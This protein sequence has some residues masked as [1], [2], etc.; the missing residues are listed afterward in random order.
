VTPSI[1]FVSSNNPP[2]IFPT[3]SSINDFPRPNPALGP[4]QIFESSASS[5]YHALQLEARKR[6]S[7][8]YGFTLAYTFSHAIDNVS[9]L[10]P[11]AGAPILAQNQTRLDLER[12]NA[13]FDIR[14][15]LAASF[16]WDLPFYRSATSGIARWL[17]GWQLAAVFQ[18]NTG[19]PFTLNLPL[20]A[21]L[22]GNLTDR[23]LSEKGL[24]FF[25]GHGA[26]RVAMSPGS[27]IN[28]FFLF[29]TDGYVGRN[30]ARGDSFINLDLALNKRFR[31][32]DR[33]QLEFRM[34]TFNLLNR[35][36]FGIPIR[37]LGAPG[38]GSSV[39]TINPARIIQFAV[40]YKF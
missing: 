26:R 11:I 8:G 9:D 4:Y 19:Q 13:N 3:S 18:S 24:V 20:D 30:T 40:K 10:F 12:G 39:D 17:G 14:H 1:P 36:N 2:L 29:R 5:N 22:D 15:R 25:D 33:Q 28:D 31:I 27:K 38:F 7:R 6:Y 34:E 23:P 21:N 35:A 16:I 32:N 37:T